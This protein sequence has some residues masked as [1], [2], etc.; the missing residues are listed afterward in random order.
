MFSNLLK[1]I[2]PVRGS[3]D[4]GIIINTFFI[5]S[6]CLQKNYKVVEYVQKYVG[7]K[8]EES[9]IECCQ[10]GRVL[11]NNNHYPVLGLLEKGDI[12]G[13]LALSTGLGWLK[14]E[15]GT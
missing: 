10:S 4:E 1:A 9:D 15:L 6:Y 3:Q 14:A 8:E 13:M 12:Q 11:R 2:Q 7:L 5:T